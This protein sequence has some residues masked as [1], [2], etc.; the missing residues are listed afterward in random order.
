MLLI[1]FTNTGTSIGTG[2]NTIPVGISY[3][4]FSQGAVLTNGNGVITHARVSNGEAVNTAANAASATL[5]IEVGVLTN[6]GNFSR[7]LTS[8]P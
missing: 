1:G 8:R 3:F 6:S 4:G 2:G 7:H 5:L